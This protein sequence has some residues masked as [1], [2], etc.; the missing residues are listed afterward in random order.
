[1]R[2]IARVLYCTVLFTGL[3]TVSGCT[4]PSLAADDTEEVDP[5]IWHGRPIKH[6]IKERYDESTADYAKAILD[7][8]GPE[9]KDLVP[10]LRTLLKNDDPKVRRIAVR[11]LGQIGP[12]AKDALEQLDELIVDPDKIVLK[13]VLGAKKRIMGLSP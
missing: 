5:G 6:W 4:I 11:L 10:A 12:N 3:V 9:D 8:V 1:M 13:E 2:R 7:Q